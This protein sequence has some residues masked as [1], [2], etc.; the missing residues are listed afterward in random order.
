[1]AP[2]VPCALQSGRDLSCICGWH[3]ELR[4]ESGRLF[5]GRSFAAFRMTIG[6]RLG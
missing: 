6:A 4:E 5:R 2:C 1:M 3:D